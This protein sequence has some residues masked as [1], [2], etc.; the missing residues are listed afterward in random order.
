MKVLVDDQLSG[1]LA[2]IHEAV[3]LRDGH[4]RTFGYFHPAVMSGQATEDLLR[5]PFSDEE[6]ARRQATPGGRPLVE[7]WKE[8]AAR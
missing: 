7:I 6:L 8:L 4:G 3:E 2:A 1:R 5:S